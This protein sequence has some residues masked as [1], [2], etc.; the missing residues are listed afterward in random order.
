M[1]GERFVLTFEAA[2]ADVPACVRIR[3]L[4]KHAG[5]VLQLRCV[6]VAEAPAGGRE[7]CPATPSEAPAVPGLRAFSSPAVNEPDRCSDR[8]WQNR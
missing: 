1:A 6:G 3:R 2:P 7:D 8:I 4:L 5:R